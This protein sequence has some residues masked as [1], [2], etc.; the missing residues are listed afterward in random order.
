L[1]GAGQ[2]SLDLDATAVQLNK[3]WCISLFNQHLLH[4][5]FIL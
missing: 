1:E 2:W 3:K 4:R 5:W